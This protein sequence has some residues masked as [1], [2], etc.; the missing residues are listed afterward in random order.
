MLG[1]NEYQAILNSAVVNTLLHIRGDVD[2][3]PS[4]GHV[5]PEFFAEA[6]HL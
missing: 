2:E 5:E 6:F 1:I 4:G 3:G